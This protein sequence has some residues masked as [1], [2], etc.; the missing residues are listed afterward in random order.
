MKRISGRAVAHDLSVDLRATSLCRLELFEDHD[1]R[2][3]TDDKTVA[4]SLKRPR[5]V[6]RIVVVRRQRSH[7]REARHA[8]R[9]DSRLSATADHYVGIAALNN[10]EAVA[11][12][13]RPCGA[14]GGGR[15]VWSFSAET[16]RDLAC[17]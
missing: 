10:P 15:G 11:D 6:Y 13:V 14:G 3:F 5:G 7:R 2:A 17:G 1:P 4:V 9:R 16:D 8:H 12:C